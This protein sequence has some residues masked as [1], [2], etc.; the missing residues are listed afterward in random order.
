M[1][2]NL[3]LVRSIY[4]DWERGD[5]TR[6]D[7][8]HRD[9][10]L[11][12]DG[13]DATTSRGVAEMGVRWREWMSTWDEYRVEADEL[14]ELDGDRVL[15]LM[16]HGGSGKASGVGIERMRSP[17]ANV[18]EMRERKVIKLAL[19][20]DRERALADLGLEE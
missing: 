12:T 10:L 2:E 18:F 11:E 19:F 20:W 1:S 13:F 16:H 15:V 6:S 7:W 9:I 4:A 8:A 17:G 5:F 3:D 14:R